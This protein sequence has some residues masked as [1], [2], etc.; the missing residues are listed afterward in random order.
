MLSYL[1][2]NSCNHLDYRSLVLWDSSAKRSEW[3]VFYLLSAPAI[4]TAI[5]T[6][7]P[8]IGLLPSASN[9]FARC[10]CKWTFTH[11]LAHYLS[12][13]LGTIICGVCW[14]RGIS[15]CK[16]NLFILPS[17]KEEKELNWRR[18][19]KLSVGVHTAPKIDNAVIST[20]RLGMKKERTLWVLSLLYKI[21]RLRSGWH[22]IAIKKRAVHLNDSP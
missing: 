6:V 5:A 13:T 12:D 8:T 16:R 7:A 4:S 3:H 20:T 9:G 1:R 14:N 15:E 19:C 21:L 17:A 22:L 2:K 10:K 11:S 18:T